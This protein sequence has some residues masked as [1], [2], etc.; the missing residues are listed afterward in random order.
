MPFLATSLVTIKYF[1]MYG[2]LYII[3]Y[4]SLPYYLVKI[5]FW[6]LSLCNIWHPQ[7]TPATFIISTCPTPAVPIGKSNKLPISIPHKYSSTHAHYHIHQL[8]LTI[9]P[10]ESTQSSPPTS[11]PG[12]TLT[13]TLYAKATL[14]PAVCNAHCQ[15][16]CTPSL[17]INVHLRERFNNSAISHI[18]GALKTTSLL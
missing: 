12:F 6:F 18:T 16:F 11:P 8:P 15:G 1:I 14:N 10:S 13:Q 3:M 5:K 17:L 2:I 9:S 4:L 7:D